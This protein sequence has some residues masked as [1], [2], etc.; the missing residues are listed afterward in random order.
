MCSSVLATLTSLS[1]QSQFVISVEGGEV[2]NIG[3]SGEHRPISTQTFLVFI[4]SL[5]R[6]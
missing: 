2:L 1:A 3:R 6:V 4:L 5:T